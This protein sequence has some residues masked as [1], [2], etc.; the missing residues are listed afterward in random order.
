MICHKDLIQ[1][2]NGAQWHNVQLVQK[3]NFAVNEKINGNFLSSS[4]GAALKDRAC[5][6]K[7]NK[8]K[9]PC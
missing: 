2:A 6:V 1:K 8:N 5:Q 4:N 3:P 9:K 7:K